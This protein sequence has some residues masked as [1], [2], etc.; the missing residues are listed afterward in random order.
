MVKKNSMMTVRSIKC[1][2]CMSLDTFSIGLGYSELFNR[3]IIML[4]H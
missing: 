2:D 3:F 4:P 1:N